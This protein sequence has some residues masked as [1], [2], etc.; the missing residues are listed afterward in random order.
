MAAHASLAFWENGTVPGQG[1]NFFVQTGGFHKWRYP[2]TWMVYFM[3]NKMDD[4]L[5]RARDFSPNVA[6]HFSLGLIWCPQSS[7]GPAAKLILEWLRSSGT[8]KL[9]GTVKIDGQCVHSVG[10]YQEVISMS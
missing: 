8:A 2:N 1:D 3:E 6:S 7:P 4:V 10:T 9:T 5:G